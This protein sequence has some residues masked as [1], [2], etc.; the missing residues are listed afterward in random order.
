MHTFLVLLLNGFALLVLLR[1]PWRQIGNLLLAWRGTDRVEEEDLFDCEA[2]PTRSPLLTRIQIGLLLGWSGHWFA[3]AATTNDFQDLPNAEMQAQHDHYNRD[4]AMAQ[5]TRSETMMVAGFPFSGVEGHGGG[6]FPDYL[7]VERGLFIL[8]ANLA[9]F[10]LAG[11]A[12]GL[13]VPRSAMTAVFWMA[14]AVA[15]LASMKGG[16]WCVYWWD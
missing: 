14:L 3:L 4:R 13:L 11:I 1:V 9:C 10:A 2:Q 7:P 15:V 6:G 12:V 8:L 5:R 16:A